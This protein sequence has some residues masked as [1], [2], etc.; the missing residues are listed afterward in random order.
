MFTGGHVHHDVELED[1][2]HVDVIGFDPVLDVERNQWYADVSLEMS[3]VAVTYWPFVRFA[4]VRFQPSSLPRASASKIV[5]SEFTQLA[6]DRE[7]IVKV[8]GSDVE[9]AVR[10]RGPEAPTSN[11]MLIAL[12]EADVGDPDELAWRPLGHGA[13]AD[14]GDDIERR[15][16][17]AVE[18][19]PDG[20]G[21]RWERTVALPGP[22]GDRTLRVVVYELEL[23]RTDEEVSA[24]RF[25]G[26]PLDNPLVVHLVRNRLLPRVVYADSV[27][28][29]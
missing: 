19:T 29:A 18:G 20:D 25:A 28:L 23:R 3:K 14:V 1:G 8:I 9:V 10:G 13:G 11:L 16:A 17:D 2:T 6:P 4:L 21:F 27:R 24:E 7:L 22:R 5:L 12:D 15:L 26:I